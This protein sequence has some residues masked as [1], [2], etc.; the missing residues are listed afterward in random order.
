[1]FGDITRFLWGS[2]MNDGLGLA[3]QGALKLIT[4]KFFYNL[5]T[6]Q[7]FGKII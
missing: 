2:F 3:R 7:F 1:M 4:Q 6:S 5:T